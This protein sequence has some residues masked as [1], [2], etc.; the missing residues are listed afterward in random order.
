MLST[1]FEICTRRNV[2]F[3][4][5]RLWQGFY[6]RMAGF[7]AARFSYPCHRCC[8]RERHRPIQE[9]LS[10][11]W[12]LHRCCSISMITKHGYRVQH[13]PIILPF[14]RF[15]F[16]Y[17]GW[18]I[19]LNK[20]VR[21]SYGDKRWIN[22]PMLLVVSECNVVDHNSN[23]TLRFLNPLPPPVLQMIYSKPS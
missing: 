5:R 4:T 10:R 8:P 17:I 18:H 14:V 9:L 7:H 3:A 12:T 20:S 16:F 15:S 6:E 19:R 11:N 1:C 21:S 22:F 23:S 2:H 13:Y